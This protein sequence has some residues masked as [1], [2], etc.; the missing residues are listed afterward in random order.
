MT[1]VQTCVFRSVLIGGTSG[2]GRAVAEAAL[3]DGAAVVVASSDPAKVDAAAARLGDG[4]RGEAVQP[5]L[6]DLHVRAAIVRTQGV[7][8]FASGYLADPDGVT[9]EAE[10]VFIQ[11]RWA[12]D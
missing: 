4:A 1:G 3:A 7:K 9:V 5:P 2:I 12:R 11:P 10:G 6:G 8:T